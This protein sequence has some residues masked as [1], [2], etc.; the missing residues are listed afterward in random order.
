M[1]KTLAKPILIQIFA[2]LP[3]PPD[4]FLKDLEKMLFFS[5]IWDKMAI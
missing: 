4:D 3:S 2:V 1:V 5:F